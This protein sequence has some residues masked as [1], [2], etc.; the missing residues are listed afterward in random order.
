[1]RFTSLSP[2]LLRR[3]GWLP[4]QYLRHIR[5]LTSAGKPSGDGS[6]AEFRI[7]DLITQHDVGAD[8]KFSGRRHL[9]LGST[10]TVCQTLIET[11]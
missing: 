7:V 10:T 11:L 1:M 2:G 3:R 6:V 9:G 4:N 8:E 5:P